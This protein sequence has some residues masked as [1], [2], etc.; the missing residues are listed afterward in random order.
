MPNL[1]GEK[2]IRKAID[3]FLRQDYKEKRLFIVDGLSSDGSH[4]IIDDYCNNYSNI[5]WIKEKDKGISNAINIGIEHIEDDDIFGYLGSDDFL[6]DGAINNI[7]ESF[8]SLIF[9]DAI[10][11]MAYVYDAISQLT[12]YTPKPAMNKKMLRRHGTIVGMQN[13]YTTGRIVKAVRFREELKYAMD[14][15]FYFRMIDK[16]KP[17]IA[18]VPCITTVNTFSNSVT[19]LNQKKSTREMLE[20]IAQHDKWDAKNIY[21]YVKTYL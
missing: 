8:E 4:S 21:K 19:S 5:Y 17:T 11:T 9:V 6:I 1:N 20:I 14:L 2:Y 12:L 18:F 15:D 3:C 7:A 13:F 16:I 10:Y